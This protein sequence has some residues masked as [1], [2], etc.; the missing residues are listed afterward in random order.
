MFVM[1]SR[2]NPPMMTPFLLVVLFSLRPAA[3][4]C[5]PAAGEGL[6]LL[7]V[8]VEKKQNQTSKYITEDLHG[9]AQLNI[10]VDSL[11]IA[12]IPTLRQVASLIQVKPAAD[13]TEHYSKLVWI[14]SGLMLVVTITLVSPIASIIKKA[15][16][17]SVGSNDS[18]ILQV[19][20]FG[21]LYIVA[22]SALIKYNKW[23]ITPGRFPYALNLTFGHQIIGS[24]SLYITY[25]L[26]P[27][28]FSSLSDAEKRKGLTFRFW[29]MAV[30]PIAVCFS[31]QLVL[32]NSAY[33]F[34]SVAFLQMMKE[35]N[36]VLVYV[37]SMLA[38]IERFESTRARILF[39][40][41]LSTSLTVQG[42]LAFDVRGFAI[43]G[44]SQLMECSKVVLQAVLLSAA[45][46]KGLDA[47]SYNLMVQPT[48]AV[49]VAAYL[50]VCMLAIPR[51]QTATL[52]DYVQWWPHLLA[53][54]FTALALNLTA[55]VFIARTSAVGFIVVGILKD[56]VLIF[57]DVLISGTPI[58]GLQIFAFACQVAFVGCYSMFKTFSKEDAPEQGKKV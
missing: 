51:I 54:G 47:L 13:D 21:S 33:E 25:L 31:G 38:H 12:E 40:L 48:T 46:S 24:V 3:A 43:Q 28:L 30:A 15:F 50:G 5:E 34:S 2:P 56:V 29:L 36:I 18:S 39:C 55:S 45:G 32:S 52:A 6:Q 20:V 49:A 41:F 23:L 1:F 4:Y 19:F 11:T 14:C 17:P 42:E 26:R 44:S 57:I 7:Q 35:A 10:A 16:A 37:L 22:S 58:S 9:K 53:N 27:A 8:A